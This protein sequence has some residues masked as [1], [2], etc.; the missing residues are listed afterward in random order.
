MNLKKLHE[1]AQWQRLSETDFRTKATSTIL[2][3]A[4]AIEKLNS[5]IIRLEEELNHFKTALRI[6]AFQTAKAAANK[7]ISDA[8]DH[9]K[10]ERASGSVSS[11]NKQNIRRV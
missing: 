5:T 2:E 6:T 3:Q 7:R 1:N 8:N 4:E 11:T 10:Q 9:D